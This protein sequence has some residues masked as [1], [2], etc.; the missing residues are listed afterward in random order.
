MMQSKSWSEQYKSPKEDQKKDRDPNP[1]I[2][3]R[4]ALSLNDRK[5]QNNDFVESKSFSKN[6]QKHGRISISDSDQPEGSIRSGES[7]VELDAEAIEK[8][9]SKRRWTGALV[10]SGVMLGISSVLYCYAKKNLN[11]GLSEK[12]LTSITPDAHNAAFFTP[13]IIAIVGLTLCT[14]IAAGVLYNKLG[15]PQAEMTEE[16]PVPE[17]EGYD[18]E[19]HSQTVYM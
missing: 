13:G 16:A 18:G 3:R 15:N 7:E 2:V 11:T 14:A 10:V 5:E 1:E 6:R 4:R 9:K 19:I 8:L 12:L 17:D